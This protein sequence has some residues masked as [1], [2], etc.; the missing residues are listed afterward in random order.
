MSQLTGWVRSVKLGSFHE[1]FVSNCKHAQNQISVCKDHY[2]MPRW[3]AHGPSMDR[4]F[5]L[6]QN[7]RDVPDISKCN[8]FKVYTDVLLRNYSA[9]L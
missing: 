9:S 1:W 8:V 5:Y 3:L 6:T 2:K 7:G 4:L